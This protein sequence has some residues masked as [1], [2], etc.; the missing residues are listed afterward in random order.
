MTRLVFAHYF[1]GS[2]R[3]WVPL[4][5]ALTNYDC[6]APDVPGFGGT[7]A[8][9]VP[10]LDA[11]AD[12]LIATAGSDP[13]VAI[14]HSMGGKIALAA[15]ARQPPKLTALILLAASPPTPEPI[16]DRDRAAMLD[17]FGNRR[18]ARA[19]LARTGSL[20]PPAM[21]K[22]A[23]DDELRV[24]EP[25]WRWWLETGSCDDISAA[26]AGIDLPVLV[27]A[28]DRDESMDPGVAPAITRRLRRAELCVIADAGHL[29][30]LERP[31][32]VADLIAAFV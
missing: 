31:R 32:A 19:Q 8:P 12:W 24:A 1:G 26:T 5:H 17:A 28:G 29:L 16:S 27:V 11:Y 13:W 7:P 20:L 4:V 6:K 21:L 9:T 2:A 23:I 22:V 10:S 15:A 25:V 3:S 18:L 14:G 30:P